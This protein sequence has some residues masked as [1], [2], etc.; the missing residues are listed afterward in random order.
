[1]LGLSPYCL[2]GED[3]QGVGPGTADC[4]DSSRSLIALIGDGLLSILP[5][6]LGLKLGDINGAGLLAMSPATSATITGSG[7]ANAVAALGPSSVANTQTPL[8]A[9]ISIL[10]GGRESE[11]NSS[12]GGVGIGMIMG[13]NRLGGTINALPVSIVGLGLSDTSASALPSIGSTDGTATGLGGFALGHNDRY[14]GAKAVCTAVYADVDLVDENGDNIA[15][16]TS[17]LFL[18]ERRQVGNGPAQYGIKNP[19]DI[20]LNRILPTGAMAI[21]SV[22]NPPDALLSILSLPLI[23]EFRSDLIRI[24]MLPTGPQ[25][26]S[27]ILSWI[28]NIPSRITDLIDIIS[29]EDPGQVTVTAEQAEEEWNRVVDEVDANQGPQGFRTATEGIE[30]IDETTV[31]PPIGYGPEEPLEEIVVREPAPA[32]ALT[33]GQEPERESDAAEVDEPAETVSEQE[34]VEVS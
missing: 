27:D 17:V 20:G 32:P 19:L 7:L 33:S 9:A 34:P 16:C 12:V 11:V 3:Q 6:D 29:G 18:F 24:V 15:S 26:E 22:L 28:V 31:I 14:R 5:I 2:A 23:P 30:I 13:N 21:M 1:M 4:S 8:S 25:I 10:V